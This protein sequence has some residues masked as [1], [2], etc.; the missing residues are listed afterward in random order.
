MIFHENRLPADNSHEVS[1][2]NLF[3][4]KQQYVKLS[5]AANYRWRCMG[6]ITPLSSLKCVCEPFHKKTRSQV[7]KTCF[8]LT[9][10][11]IYLSYKCFNAT[12]CSI[13][14]CISMIDLNFNSLKAPQSFIFQHLVLWSYRYRN[15]AL[16]SSFQS[17]GPVIFDFSTSRN[18][19]H[20]R[21]IWVGVWAFS[22]L[23]F[24]LSHSLV[25]VPT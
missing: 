9:P 4:K 21:Q 6:K 22:I 16:C 17:D 3:L 11:V 10:H 15:S 8:M 2:L 25:E 1:C 12:N 20:L 24:S 18:L 23:P 13:L 14:T 5:S 19:L 7:Y